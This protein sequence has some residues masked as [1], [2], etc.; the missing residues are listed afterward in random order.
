MTIGTLTLQRLIEH[1]VTVRVFRACK[2]GVLHG[3]PA[4]TRPVWANEVGRSAGGLGYRRHTASIAK[5]G[6]RLLVHHVL[7]TFEQGR[8]Q[9]LKPENPPFIPESEEG[10]L[11][12]PRARAW[13]RPSVVAIRETI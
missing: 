13:L 8:D 12:G 9:D 6:F 10:E 7:R 3:S 5:E 4:T 11:G 1:G 2:L